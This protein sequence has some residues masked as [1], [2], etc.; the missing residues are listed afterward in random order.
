LFN[1]GQS[2]HSFP[3][4]SGKTG[5]FELAI[6]RLL[7]RLGHNQLQ[8]AKI[9]YIAPIKVLLVLR[10]RDPVPFESLNPGSGMGKNQDPD[11]DP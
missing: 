10:I 8:P 11:P 7:A 9:V 3:S 4:G 6:V 5:I 2:I 1:C